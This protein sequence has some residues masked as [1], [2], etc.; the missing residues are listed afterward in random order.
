MFSD[1]EVDYIKSQKL[2]RIATVSS[3]SQPDVAPVSFEFDGQYFCVGGVKMTTTL[4]YKNVLNGNEKV[5]LVLDDVESVSPWR[6][7][8]IKLHGRAEIIERNGWLGEGFYLQI[9]PERYW[10]WGIERPVFED[11]KVV[12]KRETL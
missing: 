5:A 3:G 2:A 9:T 7:R 8:G 6:P 1:K 11:G 4:K 10:S 12:M